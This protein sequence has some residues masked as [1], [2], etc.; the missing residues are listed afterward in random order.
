MSAEVDVPCLQCG[1]PKPPDDRCP[2]CGMAPEFGPDRPSPFAGATLWVMIGVIVAV[3][4][5][6]LAVV[7]ITA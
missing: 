7:A 6:T 5:L 1:L 2:S 4:A 3:F